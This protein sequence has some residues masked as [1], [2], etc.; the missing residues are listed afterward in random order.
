MGKKLTIPLLISSFIVFSMLIFLSSPYRMLRPYELFGKKLPEKAGFTTS[1]INRRKAVLI[2]GDQDTE[3]FFIDQIPVTIGAY[4]DC[5]A[6]GNCLYQH[7]HDHYTKFWIKKRYEN[8]PVTFVTW[9]EAQTYCQASGGNL[10]TEH[11]WEL[12]AGAELNYDYPWGRSLPTIA[13]ANI[14]GYYQS[15]IPAG[16]LP[17]GASPYGVLDMTGNVREW[18]LDEIYADNDNKLLKGGS[19]YDNFSN[20]TIAAHFDHTPTSSGINRGFRCVYPVN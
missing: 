10:P 16:W 7:Y 12:A 4:K 14:D 20:G 18:V 3:D 2:S 17:E 1:I 11:Q 8:F 5:T 19:D 15:L 13:D 6:S 9:M